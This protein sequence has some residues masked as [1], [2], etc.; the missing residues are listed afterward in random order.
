MH[1]QNLIHFNAVMSNDLLHLMF[2]PHVICINNDLNLTIPI[3]Y[4]NSK[5]ALSKIKYKIKM[6]IEQ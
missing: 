4:V 6:S 5:L 2:F 3:S 1:F